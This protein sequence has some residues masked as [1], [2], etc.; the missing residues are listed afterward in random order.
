MPIY[1]PRTDPSDQHLKITLSP[2]SLTTVPVTKIGNQRT[3]PI[4]QPY[5]PAPQPMMMQPVQPM[6]MVP[7]PP[8]GQPGMMPPSGQPMMMPPMG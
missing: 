6:G 7:S 4:A 5:P 3:E 1:V 2:D 8:T